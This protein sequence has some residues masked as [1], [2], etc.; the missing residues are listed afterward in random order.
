[1]TK[2]NVKQEGWEREFEKKFKYNLWSD[3]DS[4]AVDMT[5]KVWSFIRNLL[6][7]A[8]KEMVEEI[9]QYQD[10]FVHNVGYGNFERAPEWQVIEDL[11]ASL[12]GKRKV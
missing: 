10:G 4:L 12:E 8:R 9:R 11:L 3:A 5:D 7:T 2:P 1:M 6:S